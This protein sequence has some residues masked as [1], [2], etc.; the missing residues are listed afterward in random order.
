MRT[1]I[2]VTVKDMTGSLNYD[3][4]VPLNIT[5]R[6]AAQDIA[7]TLN[8]YKGGTPVLLPDGSKIKNERTGKILN[9]DRTLLENGIWQGDILVIN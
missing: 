2:I 9:P 7:E 8:Y 5:A 4:E 6:R 1:A 3:V